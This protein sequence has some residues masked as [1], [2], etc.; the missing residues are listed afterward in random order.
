MT[1]YKIQSQVEKVNSILYSLVNNPLADV[2]GATI[3]SKETIWTS[4]TT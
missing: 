1:L 3:T 2:G 4:E